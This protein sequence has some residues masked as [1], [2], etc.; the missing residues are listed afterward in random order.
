V[1]VI[2][3]VGVPDA[4]NPPLIGRVDVLKLGLLAATTPHCC[5]LMLLMPLFR[6]APAVIIA[7]VAVLVEALSQQNPYTPT[8]FPVLVPV[9]LA[10]NPKNVAFALH[11][12][13]KLALFNTEPLPVQR[14]GTAMLFTKLL[15]PPFP[16]I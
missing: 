15:S 13:V 1:V 3:F 14:E 4:N 11:P 7:K 5:P 6:N 12:A 2:P 10:T 8:I 9:V 16:V